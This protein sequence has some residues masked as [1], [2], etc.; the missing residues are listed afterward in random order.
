MFP[1]S[2]YDY[3]AIASSDLQL[4]FNICR[5]LK[6]SVSFARGLQGKT[7]D[8]ADVPDHCRSISENDHLYASTLLA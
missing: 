5:D 6:S 4:K 8:E 1:K 3:K 7:A 2:R